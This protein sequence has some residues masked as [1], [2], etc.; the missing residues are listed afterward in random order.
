MVSK[1]KISILILFILIILLHL[2]IVVPGALRIMKAKKGGDHEAENAPSEGLPG[3][4][5]IETPS[6]TRIVCLEALGK[7]VETHLDVWGYSDVM[8]FAATEEA[9]KNAELF[10]F[11][12]NSSLAV[13]LVSLILLFIGHEMLLAIGAII[14]ALVYVATVAFY[15]FVVLGEYGKFI[16]YSL[17]FD[18]KCTGMFLYIAA[19][20]FSIIN[21]GSSVVLWRSGGGAGSEYYPKSTGGSTYRSYPK[22]YGK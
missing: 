16:T 10:M 4:E 22:M 1:L 12:V 9:F 20:A 14:C 11:L 7:L 21:A 3:V 13:T 15:F 8:D 19:T 5:E 6:F 18:G 17:I 2:A